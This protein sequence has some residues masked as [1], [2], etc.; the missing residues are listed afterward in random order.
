MNKNCTIHIIFLLLIAQPVFSQLEYQIIELSYPNNC[1]LPVVKS[2]NYQQEKISTKINSAI[3][4]RFMIDSST[5]YN[6]DN[7]RWYDVLFRSEIE[8]DIL[9]IE[10]EGTYYGAYD[11]YIKEEFFFDL[12][13]GEELFIKKIKL[14]SFF[15]LSGYLNFLSSYWEPGVKEEFKL[16]TECSDGSRPYCNELDIDKYSITAKTLSCSL[17]S[18]CFPRVL[19]ACEPYYSIN[20]PIDTIRGNLNII[21]TDIIQNFPSSRID[22]FLYLNDLYSFVPKNLFIFGEIDKKYSFR[23]GLTEIGQ[24]KYEGVLYYDEI[25]KA[26]KLKGTMSNGVLNLNEYHK[27]IK[28]GIL[29]FNFSK[30][31]NNGYPFREGDNSYYVN[32]I[33]RQAEDSETK[34]IHLRYITA[35]KMN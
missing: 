20:I 33:W 14:S 9:Y 3:N 6:A 4:E 7:F 27:G 15:S 17:T 12:N 1:I 10:W 18:D 32:G 25:G 11:N 21:A 34:S 8:N 30:S 31:Y 16:S 22:Q 35:T 19:R 23:L 24:N 28:T 26:I 13:D 29:N 5:Q 2:S